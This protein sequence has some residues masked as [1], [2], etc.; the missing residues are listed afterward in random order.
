MMGQT[1]GTSGDGPAGLLSDVVAGFGRLLRGELALASAEAKRSLGDA[2]SALAKLMIGAILG[3]TALNVLAGTAVAALVAAGLSPV[4]SSLVVGIGLLLV[5][6][7][8][9]R[10]A[11]AELKPAN[12]APKRM[13]ANLRHDA[14]ILK[15][16][17]ISDATSNNRP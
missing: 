6:F 11:L 12:L 14:E 2:A 9:V 5:T 16:M 1:D 4:W 13:M 3:I 17:V 10:I 15:S 7:V 8:L